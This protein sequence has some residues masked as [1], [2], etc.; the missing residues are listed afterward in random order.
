MND[1]AVMANTPGTDP[2]AIMAAAIARPLAVHGRSLELDP[3]QTTAM[4]G[5]LIVPG[6]PAE[7]VVPA[8]N[9]ALVNKVTPEQLIAI[10]ASI[11]AC[12]PTAADACVSLRR[13]VLGWKFQQNEGSEIV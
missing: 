12:A 3:S 11:I 8:G 1:L 5:G 2:R 10:V 9:G 13:E 4:G 7:L 6:R